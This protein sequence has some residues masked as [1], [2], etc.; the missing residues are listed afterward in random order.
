VTSTTTATSHVNDNMVD[1]PASGQCESMASTTTA[2]SHVN[3]NMVD[4]PA[5]G[6]CGSTRASVNYQDI[7]A[8]CSFSDEDNNDDASIYIPSPSSSSED[9]SVLRA[10]VSDTSL[11]RPNVDDGSDSDSEVASSSTD[12]QNKTTGI[13]VFQ[14][15]NG[16]GI[17]KRDKKSFCLF[18]GIQQSQ[19]VRHWIA[20]HTAEREVK[21]IMS[22]VKERRQN[23]ILWLRNLGNHTHNSEVLRT[24]KGEFQVTYR[25]SNA[26]SPHD[27]VPCEGCYAYINKKELFRHRCKLKGKSKGR[28]AAKAS[29]LLPV[30]NGV[31]SEVNRLVSGMVNSGMKQLL[32]GDDVIRSFTAKLVQKHTLQKKGYIRG[33]VNLLVRFL[34]EM[35]KHQK[36][37]SVKD[38]ICPSQFKNVIQ[39]VKSVAGYDCESGWYEKPSSALKIGH[40]LKKCAKLVKRDAILT[41]NKECMEDADYFYQLCETE[42]GDEVSSKALKTLIHR[43]R[44]KV[45]LLPI[46]EDV[47][48]LHKYLHSEMDDCTS[49]LAKSNERQE[50]EQTW[51]RLASATL[52]QIIVFNRR[53]EG[54][55]SRMT[56]DDYDRRTKSDLSA[57]TQKV[58]GAL[59]NGL[60]KMFSRVELCGKQ[61]RTVPILLTKDTETSLDLLKTRRV[62]CGIRTENPYIFAYCNSDNYL[63]GCDCLRE[64]TVQC[65]ASQR[66]RLRSTNLRKHVAT[67]CQMINLKEN[68]LDILAQYMGHD[69]R[70]HR[71][72]YRL[73]EDTLQSALLAKIFIS[74]EDGT[75][76][77]QKGKTLEDF[78]VQ[79]PKDN[80]CKY[81]C[82]VC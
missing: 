77:S 74:M 1:Q 8:N 19:I 21:D 13:V 62:Q 76:V 60:C 5:S 48:K 6:Q 40:I 41:R 4:Q 51:R 71:N 58:L 69:I 73:P 65:G 50:N 28:I 7:Q 33:Q 22:S 47:V 14:T 42:F 39:A 53:R 24:G 36:N 25:Q 68:E 63:R 3:D 26:A 29:L 57:D 82:L 43:R 54:E 79:M 55:V 34:Q 38:C 75:F 10:N 46:S 16:P 78:I 67:L 9:E 66:S 80:I 64:A 18:C 31:T 17:R 27:Y 30:P 81:T 52:T 11:T 20:K 56:V 2:T 44:N 70:I 23:Q 32:L 37:V 15:N 59:E 45:K 72:F 61:D 49:L 12:M 35:R